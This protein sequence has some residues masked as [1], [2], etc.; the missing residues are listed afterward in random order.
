MVGVINNWDILAHPLV[1]IRSFGYTIFFRAV[2]S[3]RKETFL[4]LLRSANI[5]GNCEPELSDLLQRSIELE[6]GAKRIYE[7]IAGLFPLN[8]LAHQFFLALSEQEQEHADL[9]DLCRAATLRRGWKMSY[10]D[11]WQAQ[12]PHLEQKMRAAD[13]LM[14]SITS[15][16]DALRLTVEIEASEVNQLFQ[17][18]HISSDSAFVQKMLN[19]RAA[20]EQHIS[21]I[22]MMLPELSP[23]LGEISRELRAKYLSE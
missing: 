3:G 20:M 23:K 2:F 4:S 1:I 16:D 5:F 21:Y 7:F 13:A 9:L 12:L 15:L 11:T 18:I 6:L 14:H 22:T 8:R 17:A 19:F 10:L